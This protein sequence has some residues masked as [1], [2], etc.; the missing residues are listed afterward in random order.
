[1]RFIMSIK[2]VSGAFSPNSMLLGGAAVMT[3]LILAAAALMIA[4]PQAGATPQLAQ[5]TGKA[6]GSCHKNPSGGGPLTAAG[7]KYKK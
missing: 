5:K 4:P 7:Q 3:A 2:S 1:M 6:C